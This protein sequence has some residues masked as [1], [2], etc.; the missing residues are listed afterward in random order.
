MKP[1]L[2]AWIL[3]GLIIFFGS[4]SLLWLSRNSRPPGPDTAAEIRTALEFSRPLSHFSAHG[5]RE[6]FINHNLVAYPP[7]Q[8]ILIGIQFALFHPSI[9]WAPAANLFWMVIFSL[10]AYGIGARVTSPAAG[11]LTVLLTLSM[12]L[13]ASFVREVSLEIALMA[14]VTTSIY[15]LLRSE[16]FTKGWPSLALGLVAGLGLLIKESFPIYLFFPALFVFLRKPSRISTRSLLWGLSGAAVAVAIAAVWY[17]PHW[18]D[19]TALY[20]LNRRQAVIEH[21]PMGWNLAAALFY[22]NALLNYYLNP[23]LAIFLLVS[24]VRDWRKASEVKQLV[25]VWLAGGYFLLTFIIANKDVRH[26]IPCAPAIALLV[27]DWMLSRSTRLR[28]VLIPLSIAASFLFFFASQ[29]GVPRYR[30]VIQLPVAGYEWKLWDGGLFSETVPHRENWS[31]PEL[32]SWIAGDPLPSGPLQRPLRIGVVPFV[33]RYN[34]QTLRCYAAFQNISAEFIPLGNGSDS[35][36]VHS[37]DYII[38][39]G[40]DQGASSLT[41]KADEVNQYLNSQTSSFE[42][43]VSFP[44]FDG[45]TATVLKKKNSE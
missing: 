22:P 4:S 5:F 25:L 34:D 21:D 14:L 16:N 17:A 40:G 13:V 12:T 2:H 6:V 11:L 45:T 28:R 39:K 30:G 33:Y 3:L 9:D 8:Q 29:W 41:L 15:L 36:I 27:S 32:L 42:P 35:S 26:F 31:I 38:V 18:R 37:C 43:R 19:V 7:L 20:A 10:A 23:L 24:L 44:L 1:H